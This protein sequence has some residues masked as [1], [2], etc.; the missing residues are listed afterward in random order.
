[1]NSVFRQIQEIIDENL[2]L[3]LAHVKR[4]ELENDGAI[5]YMNAQNGTEFDWFVNGHFPSF[6]VFYNDQANLGAVKLLLDHSGEAQ[7]FLYDDKGKKLVKTVTAQLAASETELQKLAAVLTRE[8]DGKKFWD[9]DITKIDADL[10]LSDAE[11]RDFL[12]REGNYALFKNRLAI[13]NLS[14]IVSKKVSDEGWKVGYMERYQPH[15]QRDSGWF[16]AAGN[17]DDAYLSDPQNLRLISVGMVWQRLDR[18]I[19]QY[20]DMPIGTKLIRSSP[21]GFEIDKNDKEIYVQKRE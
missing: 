9:G 1:M 2:Q 10:E 16:F 19:F 20:V 14:A 3:H 5:F 15:D 11:L 18:D 6:M 7:L 17:E 8:A 4:S 21:S 13:C 12:G